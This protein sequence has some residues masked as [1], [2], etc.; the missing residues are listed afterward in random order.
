[1]R[2][3]PGSSE[4]WACPDQNGR[5]GLTDQRVY[6]PRR[7]DLVEAPFGF[8]LGVGFGLREKSGMFRGPSPFFPADGFTWIE[9]R[10]E[11]GMLSGSCS[12]W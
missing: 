10:A 4:R 7:P 9:G 5:R 12:R 2:R 8:P 6:L 3:W 1:M 11:C